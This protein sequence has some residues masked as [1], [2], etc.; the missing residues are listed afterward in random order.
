MTQLTLGHDPGDEQDHVHN[1]YPLTPG[2]AI[3]PAI[4]FKLNTG[5]QYAHD[6]LSKYILDKNSPFRS[7]LLVGP[8]GT[9]KTT[10][11]NKIVESLR[12][13]HPEVS[14]GMTAPTHKAVRQLKKHSLLKDELDFGTIHSFLALKEKQVPNPYKKGEYM[15]KYE[16]EWD[17]SRGRRIDT[18]NVLIIDEASMLGD[19]LY[20]HIED[21]W[22]SRT[23][24][25][26]I[27]MGDAR[28]IPPVKEH[29][30]KNAPPMDP[31]AIPFREAQRQSRK[32][33]YLELTEIVRQAQD[34][35]IIAYA[36]D[37]R[38]QYKNQAIK[39]EFKHTANSGVEVLGRDLLKIR[40]FIAKYFD[41]QAFKDDP[42]YV[43]IVAW[44]ND[45]VNYM[46]NEVR[47]LVNKATTLPRI[48]E[49]DKL[50]LDKPIIKNDKVL[51]ANNEE[52]DV[53]SA[54][55]VEIDVKYKMIDKGNAFKQA[56]QSDLFGTDDL[57][58][59]MFS[60][61]FKAYRTS[62]LTD[63]N[64]SFVIDIL[65]EDDTTRWKSLSERIAESAKKQIDQFDKK[66][67][68]SQFFKLEK[69]FAQVKYNYCLTAHK[70]QG[71][72]YDY[73]MSM[74]WDID[75]NP[76]FEERNRIKYVAAT[77]AR[78]KLFIVK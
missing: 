76:N 50:I 44:R 69:Q 24:L 40:E 16:P 21:A 51:L 66:E 18:I 55:V 70:A 31:D 71:S 10:T 43:K 8:A 54:T 23:N 56:G 12:A 42:D 2:Q 22:R 33:G 15:I 48:I 39:H 17:R 38:M 46:N 7:Y 28:Q 77:R 11:M 74:E 58:K 73:C 19:E 9:G 6:E 29:R 78:N 60:E 41:T 32:I 75:Q 52:L 26:I 3:P 35:P 30:E 25:K 34:N 61:K 27:F 36:T 47:L 53:V 72:T 14:F 37:I 57:S 64:R 1:Q 62:V 67:M 49:G 4:T 59:K 68:W 45:T 5:Q 63:D 20:E 13:T 65:H